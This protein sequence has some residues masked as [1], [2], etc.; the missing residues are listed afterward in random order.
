MQNIDFIILDFIREHFSCPA[1]DFLMPKITLLG[2]GGALWIIAAVIL[3]IIKSRRRMGITLSAA[4]IG[5]GM[6]GNL[7]LKNIIARARP[8]SVNTAVEILIKLPT[9]YSF[10]SGHS[11]ASFAAAA[12]IFH[13]DRKLGTAVYVFAAVIAFSRLYLYVH[14]PSDVAAGILIGIAI[15]LVSCRISDG[16]SK[17]YA[18]EQN[19]A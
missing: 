2:N 3:M 19:N 5:C 12:V 8:F 11:M 10:P 18:K 16:V 14:F 17:K 13:F 9:D 4:L 15:G 7:L 6:I 1:L